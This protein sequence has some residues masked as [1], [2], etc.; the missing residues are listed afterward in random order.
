M[1][2]RQKVEAL[3]NEFPVN[4]TDFMQYVLHNYMNGSEALDCL[5][6]FLIDES[7]WDDRDINKAYTYLSKI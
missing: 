7:G 1:T 2:D 5:K 3:L 6:T 4:E